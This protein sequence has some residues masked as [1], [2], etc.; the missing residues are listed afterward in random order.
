MFQL[1]VQL[2]AMQLFYHQAHNLAKGASFFADHEALGEFYAAAEGDYDSVIERMIGTHG[3]QSVDLMQIVKGVYTKLKSVPS[4]NV[5]E[6][7]EYFSAGLQMEKEL[8][9][10][11]QSIAPSVSEGTRQMIGDIADRSEV[12][13]Y[14]LKQRIQALPH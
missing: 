7:R 1:L 3:P 10:L 11:V 14:K 2:R 9:S 6:N 5:S 8:C 4:G 12:R 13:Q